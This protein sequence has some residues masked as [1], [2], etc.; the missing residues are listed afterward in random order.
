MENKSLKFIKYALFL[1]SAILAILFLVKNTS[2]NKEAMVEPMLTWSYILLCIG[3]CLAL[4]LFFVAISK[5][6]NIKKIFT[7]IAIFAVMLVIAYLI[8]PGSEVE[9][10]KSVDKPTPAVLK[11]TD[12]FLILS[13][14]LLVGAFVAAIVGSLFKR[15]IR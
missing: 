10:S 11:M 8:A 5:G 3:I 2:D 9:V 7:V 4:V 15:K 12:T 6:G 14:I 13:V 1:V